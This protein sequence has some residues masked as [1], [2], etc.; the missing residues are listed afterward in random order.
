MSVTD[1]GADHSPAGEHPLAEVLPTLGWMALERVGVDG[2]RPLMRPPPWFTVFA[3]TTGADS[4]VQLAEPGSFLEAFLQQA[5]I[6]W[7]MPGEGT[8]NSGPWCEG[9]DA[10]G[11]AFRALAVRREGC[12]VLM[13]E[14]LGDEFEHHLGQLQVAREIALKAENLEEEV[15]R[16][17]EAIRCRE[18]ELAHR[19]LAAAGLRD[20]ETGAHVRRI[21]LYSASMAEAMGWDQERVDE[22]R[23][24]APMHDIGKIGIP[25]R[26]FRKPGRLNAGEWAIM[27]THSELGARM[28]EGSSVPMLKLAAEIAH[29]HHERYD[30]TGY[31]A[32]LRGQEIPVSARIVAIVDVYDAL[33]HP[34]V[35]KAPMPEDE[36][37]RM[38]SRGCGTHFD[39]VTFEI[40]MDLLPTLRD[41][42]LANPDDP[43]ESA[44]RRR[45]FQSSLAV[46]DRRWPP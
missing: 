13:I 3:D 29:Y 17:T 16:R 18:E 14:R 44:L 25:D 36:V 22:I 34:R 42:R 32:R 10:S 5:E 30:G 6:F 19:L 38:M 31:P 4:T 45:L 33:I 41:I 23:L 15:R 9:G 20:E 24:A 27:R 7:A 46:T 37:I 35:Y 28:L 11:Q 8:L 40:F 1:S 12:C 43:A 26:I 2:F 39:P 21:G